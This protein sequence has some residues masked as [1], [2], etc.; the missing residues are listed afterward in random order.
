MLHIWHVI[1]VTGIVRVII[2]FAEFIDVVDIEKGWRSFGFV[3]NVEEQPLGKWI[4]ILKFVFCEI[5][6]LIRNNPK[7]CYRNVPSKV[8]ISFGFAW[9][10]Q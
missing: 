1:A 3:K 9:K 10:N 7:N 5:E 2:L 4:E 6:N 8:S